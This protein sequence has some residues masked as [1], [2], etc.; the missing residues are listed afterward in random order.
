MGATIAATCRGSRFWCPDGRSAATRARADAV[1]LIATGSL[2]ELTQRCDTIVSVCPPAEALAVARQVAATGFDGLYVDANAIAPA[3]TLEIGALFPRFVDGGIIGPPVTSTDTTRMYLSGDEAGAV[4]DRWDGS[5][6][7]VRAI[8]GGVGAASAVK[9]LFAAWGKHN[10][11]LM[12]AIHAVA[13]AHG[14]TEVVRAEWAISR[15]DFVSEAEAAAHRTAAKAWRFRGE[16]HEIAATFDAA[17][18]PGEFHRGAAEVFGRL[19]HFK[20]RAGPPD[21]DEIVAAL[22]GH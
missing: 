5:L 3:T 7:D 13:E 16:M 9:M 17:G 18:L 20:D 8:D 19:A 22:L 6:L 11:A 15:P 4:S 10:A 12:F 21:L 14:V 1:G 2:V